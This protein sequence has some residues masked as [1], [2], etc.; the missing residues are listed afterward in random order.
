MNEFLTVDDVAELL[1]MNPQTIRNWIDRNELPAVRVGSRRVRVR[2]E[3]LDAFIAAGSTRRSEDASDEQP[4]QPASWEAF[5]TALT[6]AVSVLRDRD[7]EALAA[8][9]RS[10]AESAERLASA[11]DPPS[12]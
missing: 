5:G 9:L 4:E 12:D 6:N 3:D 11:I 7:P 1:R 8:A 2:R 10:L